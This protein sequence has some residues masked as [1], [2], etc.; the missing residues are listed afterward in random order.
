MAIHTELP[1]IE[2]KSY[3]KKMFWKK[4]RLNNRKQFDK[5]IKS[6][7]SDP[8]ID[9]TNNKGSWYL[10]PKQVNVILNEIYYW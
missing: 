3:S 8:D 9:F 2:V 4:I 10:C 5:M 1:T 7:D 6:L